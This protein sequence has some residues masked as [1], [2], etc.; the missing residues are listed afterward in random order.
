MGEDDCN[1]N[2]EKD[3]KSYK[4][5]FYID[6]K[7][8]ELKQKEASIAVREKTVVAKDLS[9]LKKERALK[10]SRACFEQ[11]TSVWREKTNAGKRAKL[12]SI[13]SSDSEDDVKG[14]MF[15][16]TSCGSVF[17]NDTALYRH[18]K[19]FHDVGKKHV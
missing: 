2:K 3:A 9:I 13:I 16:C 5:L 11:Q 14:K 18:R 19:R 12:F 7:F 17:K 10:N 4:T 15:I 6:R 8:D 1:E